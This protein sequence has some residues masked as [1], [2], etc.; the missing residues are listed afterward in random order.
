MEIGKIIR[1]L[2]QER[3]ETLEQLALEVGTDASNLSR[4]ERGVQQASKELLAAIAASL[5]TS[6]SSLYASAEGK[7]AQ[8]HPTVTDVVDE[9]DFTSAAIQL[10]KHFRSLTPDNQ[11]LAVELLKLLQRT[12]VGK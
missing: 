7:Q 12:Q 10:R 8:N 1:A 11:R 4:I 9:S 3:S 6:V 5:N 2:R